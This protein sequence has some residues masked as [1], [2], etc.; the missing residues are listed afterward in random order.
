MKKRQPI[1]GKAK[2]TGL[3]TLEKYKQ[4]GRIKQQR[5]ILLNARRKLI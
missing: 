2:N 1:D 3:K 5:R 4:Q